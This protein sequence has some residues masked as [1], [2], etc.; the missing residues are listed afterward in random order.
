MLI[1]RTPEPG[2]LSSAFH[3]DFVQIPNIAGARL[4]PQV[5]CDLG[6]ELGDLAAD[7]LV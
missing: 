2:F 4:P 7:C 3:N 6:S 1:D 5:A